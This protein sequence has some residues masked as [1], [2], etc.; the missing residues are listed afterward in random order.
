MTIYYEDDNDESRKTLIN[1]LV[2]VYLDFKK[3]MLTIDSDDDDDD[4]NPAGGNQSTNHNP[5]ERQLQMKLAQQKQQLRLQQPL[6]HSPSPAAMMKHSLQLLQ[7]PRKPTAGV[8]L[9]PQSRDHSDHTVYA[10]RPS[11]SE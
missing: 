5:S 7:Q 3:L 11:I 9:D 2:Q 10:A 4:D 6:Q 1:K 8:M